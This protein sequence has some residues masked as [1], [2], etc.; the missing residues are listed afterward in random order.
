[1]SMAS[2]SRETV[3]VC[4]GVEDN[5]AAV[6]LVGQL[7]QLGGRL[8][9]L[10]VEECNG[11]NWMDA[12]DRAIARATGDHMRAL[13]AA[14]SRRLE[15]WQILLDGKVAEVERRASSKFAELLRV[16]PSLAGCTLELGGDPRGYVA[17]VAFPEGTGSVHFERGTS[18]PNGGRVHCTGGDRGQLRAVGLFAWVAARP[19]AS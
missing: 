14:H 6:V 7:V 16:A 5:P 15:Q 3:A 4:F 19:V 10:A 13:V 2:D 8:D 18:C 9:R 11:P 1:M 17:R 12:S